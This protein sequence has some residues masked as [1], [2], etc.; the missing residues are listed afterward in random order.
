MQQFESQS[1]TDGDWSWMCI[2]AA[3]PTSAA[4]EV[5]GSAP[6]QL[7][8]G[9]QLISFDHEYCTTASPHG[10]DVE[11]CS[12]E[13][14]VVEE[15]ECSEDTAPPNT[16]IAVQPDVCDLDLSILADAELWDNLEQIIDADQLLGQSPPITS[17]S[18]EISSPL[19]PLSVSEQPPKQMDNVNTLPV[20]NCEGFDINSLLYDSMDTFSVEPLSSQST[21]NDLDTTSSGIGS[22][23]SD[24]NVDSDDY[25][26]HWEESFTELF[27]ALA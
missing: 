20:Q 13:E 5:V 11:V 6:A 3:E 25:G 12:Q 21:G 19:I 27:P 23:L 22:P 17:F 4:V 18:T 24:E 16:E 9:K 26:F 14:V 8:S 15:Q 2:A 7:E 1:V 10:D